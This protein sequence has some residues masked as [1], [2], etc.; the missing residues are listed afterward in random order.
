MKSHGMLRERESSS[1]DMVEGDLRGRVD[2]ALDAMIERFYREVPYA[3]NLRS[4]RD[5]DLDYLKRHTIEIILRLRMKRTVDALA[6]RYFT[7]TAP[8][9]AKAWAEYTA[10]EM[11]HDAFFV[12][13]LARMGVH[14]DA[15]YAT[16]PLFSTKLQLGYYYQALEHEGD[17]LALLVSVYFMEYVTVKTQPEW[18]DNFERS[19]G[20][21]R[22]RGA[23]AHVNRDIDDK[24]ADF[25]WRVL[26]SISQQPGGESRLFAHLD[27]IYRLWEL[28][29]RELHQSII[30]PK[31]AVTALPLASGATP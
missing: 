22:L 15:V 24:H 30:Q 25:V 11:L 9:T 17:P 21:E 13:D 7:K 29:F 6:I 18:L 8:V 23:R 31:Q 16:E 10:E 2:A 28:Y 26:A 3:T 27:A 12:K 5:L 1:E 4:G 14:R 19:V 20:A